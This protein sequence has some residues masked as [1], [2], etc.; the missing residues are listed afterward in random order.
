MKKSHRVLCICLVWTL[1]SCLPSH[2][3]GPLPTPPF[4]LVTVDPDATATATPFQP[5]P[6][7]RTSVPSATAL[8]TDTAVP[9]RTTVPTSTATPVPPPATD[10]RLPLPIRPSPTPAP[11]DTRTQYTFYVNLRYSA[12]RLHADETIQYTNTTGQTLSN[13]VLAVVPNLSSDCFYLDSIAQDGRALS[14]YSLSGQRLTVNLSQQLL[15][16]AITT[17]ALSFD[18]SV[19]PRS[20]EKPF[21]YLDNQLNLSDWYPFIVPYENGWVLHN[22][23]PFGEWLVYDAADYDVNLKVDDPTV[24]IAASAPEQANGAWMQYRSQAARTFVLSASNLFQ[25]DD[26][27]VGSVK[28]YSYYFP[29]DENASGEVLWMATQA[30]GLYEAKFAP[31][32]HPTISIVET[33]VPDGQEYDGLVFLSTSFYEKYN[34]TAK[35]DLVTIGAHELAHQWWFGLVGSDQ[36]EE[37]WLDES[38]AVYTEHIFYEYNYPNYGNWWWNFRTYNF[39]PGGYV[40]GSIYDYP[41]FTSYVSAVYMNGAEFLDALRTRVGDDAYFAFLKDYALRYAHQHVTA[42]DFF[43]TLRLHTSTNF[44]DIIQ[45][46]FQQPH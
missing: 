5:A 31:Y 30:I 26:T 3:A 43:A 4:D 33:D 28:I 39:P 12:H 24:R 6:P 42:D 14:D 36:A 35:S 21:G 16:D 13:V 22:S 45:E 27:A 25:I 7:T 1:A 8:P 32:P 37:P 20:G 23:W 18:L 29:G 46:Y 2:S 40:D 38:M 19:P 44:S 15:P 11:A 10:T 41:T 34:G 17:F 9:T